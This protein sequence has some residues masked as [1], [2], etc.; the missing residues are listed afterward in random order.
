MKQLLSGVLQWVELALNAVWNWIYDPMHN[1][2]EYMEEDDD[3]Y[4]W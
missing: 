1:E 3:Y 2:D 4:W